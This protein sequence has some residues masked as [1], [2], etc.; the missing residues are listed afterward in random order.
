M[1]L[2][3][4]AINNDRGPTHGLMIRRTLICEASVPTVDTNGPG[5]TIEFHFMPPD[6]EDKTKQRAYILQFTPDEYA[7][8]QRTIGAPNA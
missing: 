2:Y 1:K 4:V 8:L 7:T 5:D 3:K 6:K